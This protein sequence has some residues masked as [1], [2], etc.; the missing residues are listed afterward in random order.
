MK[1]WEPNELRHKER[2]RGR[3]RGAEDGWHKFTLSF[4]SW[5]DNATQAEMLSCIVGSVGTSD[6]FVGHLNSVALVRGAFTPDV[7]V[8][9]ELRSCKETSQDSSC[10]LIYLFGCSG[11]S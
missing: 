1:S 10:S 8:Q 9:A 2:E 4:T 11:D 3:D 6:W 7:L 5:L